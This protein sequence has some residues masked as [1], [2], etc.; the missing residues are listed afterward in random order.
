M[1]RLVVLGSASPKPDQYRNNTYLVL[2]GDEDHIL[3]DCA[4]SPIQSLQR[5]G[6]DLDRLDHLIVTHR[7]PD[8]IYGVPVLVLG[9]WL[10]GR[11]RPLVVLGEKQS[12]ATISALLEIFRSEEWPGRFPLLYSEIAMKPDQLVLD[13]AEFRITSIPVKHLV[14]TLALKI[15]VKASGRTVVYSSDTEP[16]ETLVEFARGADLLIHEATGEG[17]GHSSSAQAG[18]IARRSGVKELML[19][20]LPLQN[21]SLEDW[22]QQAVA[23]FG[24]AVYIAN[25]FDSYEL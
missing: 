6:V 9:L 4:G 18:E 20:H 1:A 14:P 8:H 23:I 17:I 15:E 19:I 11:R 10:C 25:D 21:A 5:M 12:L 24:G 3:I 16:C 2:Q 22:R 13:T 7:H